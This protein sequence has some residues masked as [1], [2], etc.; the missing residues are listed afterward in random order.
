MIVWK[1]RGGLNHLQHGLLDS[2]LFLSMILS[3]PLG[4]CQVSGVEATSVG[5]TEV[6]VGGWLATPTFEYR[7]CPH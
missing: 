2:R 4:D 1:S 3:I 5:G 6:C 7:P